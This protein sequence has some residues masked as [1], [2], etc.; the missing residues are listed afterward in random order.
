VENKDRKREKDRQWRLKNKDRKCEKDR[1]WRL[2]NKDRRYKTNRRWKLFQKYRLTEHEYEALLAAQ[3]GTCAWPG[4]SA[5]TAGAKRCKHLVVDHSHTT[6][7]VRGLLCTQH[8]RKLG[9]LEK[10]LADAQTYLAKY[11]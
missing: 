8:N 5:T 2:K 3:G 7:K 6:G 9:I 4:C 10:N 1:Q 11:A